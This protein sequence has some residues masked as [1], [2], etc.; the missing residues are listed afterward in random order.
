MRCMGHVF[1]LLEYSSSP[2]APKCKT[3]S[4]A[5]ANTAPDSP[6]LGDCRPT[7]PFA[8][9]NIRV[10]MEQLHA[11]HTRQDEKAR[12]QSEVLRR[13]ALHDHHADVTTTATHEAANYG[14]T[15]ASLPL[16]PRPVPA[17]SG[18]SQ[19]STIDNAFVAQTVYRTADFDGDT[20]ERSIRMDP[21]WCRKPGTSKG[22]GA[23]FLF[24][25]L[26]LRH[27]FPNSPCHRP[28]SS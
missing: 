2:M 12:T 26:K 11:M 8:K 21:P 14:S 19:P 18:S 20:F 1:Q 4:V 6:S 13:D 17:H 15:G 28:V 5:L 23:L 24:C 9:D 3:A 27:S 10:V 22:N 25:R 7:S 16:P